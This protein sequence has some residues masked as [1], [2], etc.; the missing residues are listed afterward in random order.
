MKK[1]NINIDKVRIESRL[2]QEQEMLGDLFGA[3]PDNK[4]LFGSSEDS[5]PRINRILT[6][7]GGILKSED[8]E[9]RT[10]SFFGI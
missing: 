8:Y 9:R 5:L 3:N 6:S 7:G 1:P 4:V 2:S 10:G